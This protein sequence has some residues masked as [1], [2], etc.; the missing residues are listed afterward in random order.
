[1]LTVKLG[2][3]HMAYRGVLAE[4]VGFEPTEAFT[5]AVFKTAAFNHSATFPLVEARGFEP[6]T[7]CLQSSCSP[8][9]L[10]PRVFL[11]ELLKCNKKIPADEGGFCLFN[12]FP[13]LASL[14]SPFPVPCPSCCFATKLGGVSVTDQVAK[15]SSMTVERTQ[16]FTCRAARHRPV[17]GAWRQPAALPFE[18]VNS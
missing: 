4:K 2:I 5:S 13:S 8:V 14:L 6:R 3:R 17:Q 9:E 18:E 11:S 1:M 12:P 15:T 7:F 10:C 16:G